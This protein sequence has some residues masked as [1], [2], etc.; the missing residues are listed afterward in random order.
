VHG[1]TPKHWPSNGW[2]RPHG[3]ASFVSAVTAAPAPEVYPL[4]I[5][6]EGK[7]METLLAALALIAL[8]SGCDAGLSGQLQRLRRAAARHASPAAK[9]RRL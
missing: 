1:H 5:E 7:P 6:T 8:A 3:P 4:N 9:P 2:D